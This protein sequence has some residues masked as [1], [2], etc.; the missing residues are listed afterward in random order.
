MKRNEVDI[1]ETWKIEDI[2]ENDDLFFKDVEKLDN[3]TK[4]FKENYENL[5]KEN[6]FDAIKDYE[7]I[8][9]IIE[10]TYNY[11][12]IT[13]EA[14]NTDI[15]VQKRYA[16]LTQKLAN[17]ESRCSFFDLS[18]ASLSLDSFNEIL[19]KDS[20]YKYF[21]E[22][23]KNKKSHMLSKQTE[24]VMAKLSPVFDSF[25]KNYGDM[26]FSDIS[27]KDYVANGKNMPLSYNI[28]EEYTEYDKDTE[29]RRNGFK[30]FSDE[31]RK[32]QNTN[33]SIYNSHIQSEKIIS[34][35]RGY[36]SVFD[37]LLAKQ[38]VP[39]DVYENQ[40]DVI[41]EK[42]PV[43]M[44]KYAKIIEKSQKLEK[45]TYA[46]LKTSVDPEYEVEISFKEAGEKICDGLSVLGDEY[47][48]EV[49]KRA[50]NERWID[51]AQ[52]DG[53]SN[54]A[55][56]TTPYLT[57]AFI[58]TSFNNKMSQ[59]MTLAH[60]LGHAGQGY[61]TNKTQS[62]LNCGMSMYFVE[63]P[64]TGNEITMEKYLLKNAK[65]DRE[66]LYILNTMIS[67]TYYHNFVTHFIESYFQRE[68]YRKVDKGENLTAFDLNTI[69]RE[70]LEKFWGKDVLLT[71][72]CE[73]TWMRQPHY[74]M[75]LYPY[76][77]AAGLTIGT[78]VSEK[79]VNGNKNDR[80]NWLRV[81]S[82]GSTKGP[83][84][85]AKEAGID[86]TSTKPIEETID[87]I[88]NLIDEIDVLCKKLK[89]Y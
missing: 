66:K 63:S 18:L 37:Y 79:L 87:Y 75:G 29:V 42:L 56:C 72:G 54:G 68:V 22:K 11:A 85:L 25:Y 23:I 9:A 47:V 52:N 70:T 67:K 19:K 45:I 38:D 4:K 58:L 49:L 35:I 76:T 82:L 69:F 1:N 20:S 53:K 51:Y 5:N 88:G 24:E 6:A 78:K 27:F 36:N 46:D 80:D 40:I 31:I 26:K 14:D 65:D 16:F 77:Y 86:M 30:S 34:N 89:I 60:E 62:P 7:E 44:R 17:F 64:S 33:A 12:E 59:V 57:H 10:K 71:E 83:L 41:M 2:Y 48:N 28:F 32:Y 15:N 55:F 61:F 50:F 74:Y 81:L 3:L 21:I 43:H 8:L 73:L 84:D 39:R 13:L